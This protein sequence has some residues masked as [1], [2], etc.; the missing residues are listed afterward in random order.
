MT[1][2]Q[3]TQFRGTTV[4]KNS[5]FLDISSFR[6]AMFFRGSSFQGAEFHSFAQ[7]N[8]VEF[9]DPPD[10]HDAKVHSNT[11]FTNTKF[12]I[13]RKG[14]TAASWFRVLKV[15]MSE[16][17]NRPEEGRFFA[18]EQTSMLTSIFKASLW[19][20]WL[21]QLTSNYEQS[22]VLPIT[23]IAVVIL[24]FTAFYY[25]LAACAECSSLSALSYS[26]QF[27]I[28]QVVRPFGVWSSSPGPSS[29]MLF[30]DNIDLGIKLLASAQSIITTSLLALALLAL[31]W[32]F[33]RG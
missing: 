32:R 13:R 33:R 8:D 25:L 7:F 6:K 20:S 2:F 16:H 5:E 17:Q 10:F 31:R 1:Q 15:L 23:E 12:H 28:E 26:V 21:Y 11:N 30:N 24:M 18:L 3:E 27:S 19:P 14:E 9:F 4:S 22:F 29:P